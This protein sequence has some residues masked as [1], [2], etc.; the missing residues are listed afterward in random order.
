MREER[1]NGVGNKVLYVE[2]QIQAG[3]RDM[4]PYWRSIEESIKKRS[5]IRSGV[6]TRKEVSHPVETAWNVGKVQITIQGRLKKPDV[7]GNGVKYGIHAMPRVQDGHRHLRI[8]PNTDTPATDMLRK[9][10]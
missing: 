2:V 4:A 6:P 9:D 1:K 10:L 5:S 8:T 3:A 7:G